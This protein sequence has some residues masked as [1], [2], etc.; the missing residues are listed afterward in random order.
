MDAFASMFSLG[1]GGG[2]ANDTTQGGRVD[3]DTPRGG[4]AD[5]N[6]TGGRVR[7]SVGSNDWDDADV[8]L[9]GDDPSAPDV[10][11]RFG[12]G[13]DTENLFALGG[14][15]VATTEPLTTGRQP[16]RQGKSP[17]SRSGQSLTKGATN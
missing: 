3:G 16:R 14:G 13:G 8:R 5:G 4:R 9:T 7:T 1:R 10:A 17:S 15:I 6:I 2:R 11:A 12:R